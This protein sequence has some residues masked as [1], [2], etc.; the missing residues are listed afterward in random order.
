MK[1]FFNLFFLATIMLTVSC[2]NKDENEFKDANAWIRDSMEENYLWNERVPGS[3][4]GSIPPGAFFG[5]MLDPNDFMSFI[6]QDPSLENGSQGEDFSYGAGVSPAFGAFSNSQIIFI[7]AEFIYPNSSAD[8]A[9]LERGDIILEIDGTT[10]TTNNYLNLFYSSNETIEYTLGEYNSEQNTISVTNE[11]VT[12]AQTN[13]ELNPVVHKSV[14]EQDNKKIGYLFYPEFKNGTNDRYIDS[15]DAALQEFKSEGITDVIVDLRYNSGGD[16]SSAENLGNA[17]T[18]QSAIQNEE[19]FVRFKYNDVIEQRIIDEEGAESENLIRRFSSD[20]ENLGIGRVYF[21]T[22]TQ[23]SATSELLINGLIPHTNVKI[24]GGATN[25]QLFGSTIINGE[26]AV[27]A[28]SYSIVPVNLRLQNSEESAE[29]T[30]RLVPDIEVTENLFDTKPIGD[31]N[32]P[33]L[34]A[35]LQDITG[36]T[37]TSAKS[38]LISYQLLPDL[39]AEQKGRLL[40]SK[41]N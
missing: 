16:F 5:S 12:V 13:V 6:V 17:L 7:V 8:T 20:P 25:G 2:T 4:D 33:L 24:V 39:R 22:T 23:T 36:G 10:L 3:V 32:D 18:S 35:A 14:I 26:D 34:S 38:T 1:N 37:Q 30:Y 21:L 9:G 11:I 19:I 40:F 29:P 31:V 27:P 15:V 41:N 28:I